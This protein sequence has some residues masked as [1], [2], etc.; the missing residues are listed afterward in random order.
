MIFRFF[1]GFIRKV[2]LVRLECA[3][4]WLIEMIFAR[5]SC[6]GEKKVLPLHS[7]NQNMVGLAQLV[8]AS[9]CGSEGRGFEPRR[10]PFFI[11]L[12]RLLRFFCFSCYNKLYMRV[13][14]TTLIHKLLSPF[15]RYSLKITVRVLR[16]EP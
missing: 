10:S 4:F 8:R 9:D 5:K 15:K 7:L 3:I 11:F 14:I 1:K 12:K 13:G 16:E 2:G 6:T